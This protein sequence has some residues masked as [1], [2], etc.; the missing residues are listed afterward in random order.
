MATSKVVWADTEYKNSY[1]VVGEYTDN[2]NDNVVV[3]AGNEAL[4]SDTSV[5]FLAVT[6]PLNYTEYAS[7][8]AY[9][10]ALLNEGHNQVL[11][12]PIKMSLDIDAVVGAFEY[13]IDFNLGDLC[14]IELPE[15][16]ISVDA[17]LSGCI[18]VIK[19]GNW[20]LTLEF[21]I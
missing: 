12:K 15:I 16:G 11:K 20:T 14:S 8:A 5:N 17:V 6:A 3:M 2:S 7:I 13:M 19:A 10:E 18:E 9:K 4:E 21:D 1:V